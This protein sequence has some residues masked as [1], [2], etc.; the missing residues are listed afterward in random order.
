MTDTL[1][2]PILGAPGYTPDDSVLVAED[3]V[4]GAA[5]HGR[6]L[7]EAAAETLTE[8]DFHQPSRGLAFAAAV[9]LAGAGAWVDITSVARR[10]EQ[11]GDMAAFRGDVTKLFELGQMGAL[12]PASV[13]YHA[14]TVADDARRRRLHQACARGVQTAGS[15]GFDPDTDIEK[16]IAD[17]QAVATGNT[18]GQALMV[19]DDFDAYLDTLEQPDLNPVIP[20]PWPDVDRVVK[21][22]GGQ[23]VIVGARPGGGKS[24]V[25]LNLAVHTAV[26]RGRPAALFSMEMPRRQVMDRALAGLA[27]VSLN[28]FEAREFGDWDWPKLAK[29]SPALRNAPLLID[30]T[31]NLSLPH[32]RT[33]LRWMHGQGHPAEVVVIDYLQLMKVD[34]RAG[35]SRVQQLGALSRGLKLLAI[36]FGIPVVALTQ[37]NRASELRTV[38]IPQLS[39]LRESGSIENDADIVMLLHREVPHPDQP[40]EPGDRD[41]LGEVDLIVAKNR[42]GPNQI[43]VPLSWQG[44]YARLANLGK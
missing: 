15:P 30:D 36:E 31:A 14:Q 32:I 33:R 29:H 7:A 26:K 10:L 23:L 37:L 20:T 6:H 42:Q 5:I 12:S 17:V 3:A 4:A 40:K 8:A 38:K 39:D 16:V 43:T 11:T 44:H 41:W 25:G 35:E 13:R 18:A 9:H 2:T 34:S 19:A 1:D 24:I 27:G 21:L 22:R 28:A